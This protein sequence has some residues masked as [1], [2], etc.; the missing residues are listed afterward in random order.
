[1]AT[2]TTSSTTAP[3]KTPFKIKETTTREYTGGEIP[4]TNADAVI[5]AAY[6]AKLPSHQDGGAMPMQEG[7]MAQGPSHAQGGIEVQQEDTGEPVAEIEGGE[8][9]FSVEDTQM[10]E[11][12]AMQIQEAMDGGDQQ[13]AEDLAMRLGFAVVQMIAAQEQNQQ[14]QEGGQPPMAAAPAAPAGDPAAMA[15]NNFSQEPESMETLQ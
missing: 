9:I 12:A 4:D 15:A 13:Q 8:R 2:S 7:G 1:M 11:E 5:K 14:A 6:G 3:K 10:L